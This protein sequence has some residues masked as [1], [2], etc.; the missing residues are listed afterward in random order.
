M[1]LVDAFYQ[2]VPDDPILG[3]MYPRDDLDGA[4]QRLLKFLIFRCGGPPDYLEERGHPA[5]R[6]RH[7]L[8][9]IDQA[10]RDRWVLLMNNAFQ[11]ANLSDPAAATLQEFLASTAT[12][13]MN[14]RS[15]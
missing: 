1:R 8:F 12:F 4:R 15:G 9:A 7:A 13:L 5:L 6:M 14:R 2:Q 10:A 11:T 3:P